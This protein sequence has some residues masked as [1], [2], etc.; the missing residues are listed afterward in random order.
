[1][2]K[3]SAKVI[4]ATWIAGLVILLPLALTFTVLAWAFSL[5]NRFVGPGS[6]AGRIFAA[7]GYPFTSHP[8]LQYLFG[9]VL[10]VV[11]IYVLGLIVQSGLKG[12]L[13]SL[14]AR[15]VRRIP[16]VG[17][18]YTLADRFVGLLDRTQATDIGAMS[19]VWCFFGG[20]GAAV[21]ALAPGAEPVNIGDQR[22]LPVLVPSAPVPFSGALLFVPV[23]WLRPANIGVDTLT[24]IYVSLGLT[25]PPSP[26]RARARP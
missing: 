7:I 12:P 24:A 9:T 19:P 1:M 10:L 8:G 15:A 17:A 2:I 16:I 14:S 20:D 25:T 4:A 13:Q 11:S 21:L 22:Y 3:R 26:D 5:V 23:D 18:V 6:A